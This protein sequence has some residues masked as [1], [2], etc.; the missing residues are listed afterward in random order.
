MRILIDIGHPAHVHMFKNIVLDMQT[1]RHVFFFTVRDGENE[2]ELLD[3]SGF[4]YQRIGHKRKGLVNKILGIFIYSWRILKAAM[5]FKPDLFLSHGSMYAGYASFFLHKPH[6]ALEDTGNMEQIRL[7]LPVSNVVLTP[8]VLPVNL[9]K[10]QIRYRGYHELMYLIPKY[11]RPDPKIYSYLGLPEKTPYAILRFISWEASHDIGE[12]GF[13][14]EYKRKLIEMLSDRLKVFISGERQLPEEFEPFKINIPFEKMHDVLAFATIYIGE[15]ATMASEAGI[16]GT[17]SIYV[18]SGKRSYHEDHEKYG[19]VFNFASQN[20]VFEKIN[21]ILSDPDI[22]EKHAILSKRL[23]KSKI[24]V[25]SFL[26]WFIEHY[27]ESFRI[28][29]DNPEYQEQFR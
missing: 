16:L 29:K 2:T 10:K 8:D 22:K 12:S 7:S 24:D 15:G 11:F 27:P 14:Q 1:R 6:I 20:G 13:S 25:T 5:K 3:K 21:E 18:N 23:I 17:P 4:N 28:M 26:V 19:T 9:G